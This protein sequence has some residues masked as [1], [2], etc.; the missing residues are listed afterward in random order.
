MQEL[1]LLWVTFTFIFT[2][3]MHHVRVRTLFIM[4]DLDLH[5]QGHDLDLEP[6]PRGHVPLCGAY[7]VLCRLAWWIHKIPV[8]CNYLANLW[9]ISIAPIHQN[10]TLQTAILTWIRLAIS[11]N[12]SEIWPHSFSKN[13]GR[14]FWTCLCSRPVESVE[15]G[16]Q[17]YTWPTRIEFF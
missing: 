3:G 7:I 11:D 9:H 13:D 16:S 2:P 17:V 12:I 10:V 14:C 6:G 8:S 5:L 15:C 4:G 1:Y